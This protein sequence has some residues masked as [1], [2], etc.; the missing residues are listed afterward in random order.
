MFSFQE[1]KV[2]VVAFPHAPPLGD[3]LLSSKD[4]PA[5]LSC[6][7]IWCTTAYNNAFIQVT[8]E[9]IAGFAFKGLIENL[10]AAVVI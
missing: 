7:V 1:E 10:V 5:I 4:P 2:S 9:C 3:I 8:F 6:G